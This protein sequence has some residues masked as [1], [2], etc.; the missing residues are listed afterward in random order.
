MKSIIKLSFFLLVLFFS[1]C[2]NESSTKKII[3]FNG[4]DDV[5]VQ[6]DLSLSIQ[7]NTSYLKDNMIEVSIDSTTSTCGYKLI[8]GDKVKHIESVITDL[9]LMLLCKQFFSELE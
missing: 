4:C 6:Q 3:V 2:N 1:S 8:Y 7:G 9:D 5:E